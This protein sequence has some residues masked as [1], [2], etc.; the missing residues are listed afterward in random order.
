MGSYMYEQEELYIYILFL[1]YNN[2]WKQQ[3]TTW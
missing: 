1:Q 3:N 2:F